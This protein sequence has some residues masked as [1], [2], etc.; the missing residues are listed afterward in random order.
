MRLVQPFVAVLLFVF[1]C[2]LCM[3]QAAEEDSAAVRM[4][5]THVSRWRV[6]VEIQ[7]TGN[8]T[9]IQATFPIFMDWPEQVVKVIN[10]DRSPQISKPTIRNLDG[11]K[12][13]VVQIPRMKAGD[14][15]HAIFTYEIAR[16]SLE[17]P[18]S[19]EGLKLPTKPAP[20]LKFLGPSPY[21]EMHDPVLKQAGAAFKT[22]LKPWELAEAIYDHVREKVKYKFDPKIKPAV[23]AWKEGQGDCEE[24]TSLFIAFCRQQGIPARAVWVPGHC[25]AEFYLVDARGEGHWYPCQ[26]AGDRDFGRMPEERPILQ[27]GDNI[28]VPEEKLP[29]RY[30]QSHIKAANATSD[31]VVKFILERAK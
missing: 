11:V 19:H 26:P 31:P 14:D 23:Q 1:P 18:A 8:V 16:K 12:Q 25:Y 29:Q 30:V 3:L 2:A 20:L 22:D 6:G 28:K 10:E 9:G 7:T 21:I 5:E 4:G 13:M 17:S 24:L 15:F 27:K